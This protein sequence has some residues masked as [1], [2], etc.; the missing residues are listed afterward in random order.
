MVPS[1]RR[2]VRHAALRGDVDFQDR[3]HPFQPGPVPRPVFLPA[4]GISDEREHARRRTRVGPV[5]DLIQEESMK[6]W[7]QVLGTSLVVGL[8][9]LFSARTRS[10]CQALIF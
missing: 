5:Q 2:A 3:H 1:F 8:F 7:R 6:R 4:L 9:G 10:P